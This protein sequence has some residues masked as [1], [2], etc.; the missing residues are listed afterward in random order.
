MVQ[1]RAHCSPRGG[2]LD[3][4]RGAPA[5]TI[6]FRPDPSLFLA[7]CWATRPI[8]PIL[9]LFPAKRTSHDRHAS[10]PAMGRLPG[11]TVPAVRSMEHAKRAALAPAPDGWQAF[12]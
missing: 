8:G 2:S 1:S 7:D 5:D 9:P 11:F 10:H 4:I 12:R 3:A 6:R